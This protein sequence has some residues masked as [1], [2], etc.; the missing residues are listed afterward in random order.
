MSDIME[1]IKGFLSM[2]WN[3]LMHTH[4]P[5]TDIAFGVMF[6]GLAVIDIGFRFLSLAIGV[7][8]GEAPDAP[9]IPFSVG[10]VPR[11][12]TPSNRIKISD[13]RKNDVR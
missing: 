6:V 9:I 12:P 2:T 3:F 13:K 8:V 10:E 5:G 1:G 7:N 11:L 4:I